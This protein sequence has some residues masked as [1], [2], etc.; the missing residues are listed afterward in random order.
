M[1]RLKNIL[2]P[3]DGSKNSIRGLDHAV[4]LARQSHATITGFYVKP[5]PAVYALHRSGFLGVDFSK[6][7][8]QILDSAKLRAAKKGILFKGKSAKGADPG[9]DIVSFAHSKKNKID[10]IVIGARG[11]SY[12][13]EIFFG[14]VS[15]YVIHKSKKPVLLV[16]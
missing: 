11:I 2:V 6:K 4:L 9:F 16:K 3:L 8:K 14:S 1:K 10:L 5:V 13:R 12:A 15:N 7:A